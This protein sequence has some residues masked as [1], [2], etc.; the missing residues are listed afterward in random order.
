MRAEARPGGGPLARYV[1]NDHTSIT[2]HRVVWM[3][4]NAKNCCRRQGTLA[5]A[6]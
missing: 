6:S 3:T 1:G 5:S 4:S 2:W